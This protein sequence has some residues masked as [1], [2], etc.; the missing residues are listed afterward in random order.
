MRDAPKTGRQSLPMVSAQVR[1]ALRKQHPQ[2]TVDYFATDP[3]PDIRTLGRLALRRE[4]VNDQFALGDMCAERA[5]T[6]DNRLLVFYVG[7]TIIAYR[8]ALQFSM[9]DVDRTLAHRA[10]DDFVAW[11]IQTAHEFPTRRN[12][13]VALWTVAETEASALL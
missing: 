5:F 11:V 6:D 1:A 4:D 7:K 3:N 12:L 9:N 2:D 8:R 13:A 10:S